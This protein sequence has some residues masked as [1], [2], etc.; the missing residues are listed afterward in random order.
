MGKRILGLMSFWGF[1]FS[2]VPAFADCTDLSLMTNW[3]V[4]GDQSI[5][6]YRGNSPLAQ[7][8]LEDCTV[9][10]SSTIRF[11]KTYVCDGDQIMVDGQACNI[12]AVTLASTSSQ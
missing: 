5:I 10:A 1:L 4:Q 2:S 3:Y 6:F 12:M 7:V 11:I 9:N 8:D